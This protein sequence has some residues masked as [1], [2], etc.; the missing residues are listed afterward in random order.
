MKVAF[1]RDESYLL[2]TNTYCHDFPFGPSRL[3][4]KQCNEGQHETSVTD[5]SN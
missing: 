1:R 4:R 2:R 3:Y 5:Y